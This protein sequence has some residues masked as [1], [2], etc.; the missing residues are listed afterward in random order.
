M[1][2]TCDGIVWYSSV[3]N[4][5]GKVMSSIVKER[6]RRVLFRNGKVL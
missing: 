4:S 5:K 1:E 6:Y 3:M 2:L